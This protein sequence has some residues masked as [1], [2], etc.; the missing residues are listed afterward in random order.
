MPRFSSFDSRNYPTVS[1]REGY[2]VWSLTYEETIKE[3]AEPE[4]KDAAL[5]AHRRE[6]VVGGFAD[7]G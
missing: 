7:F 4:V 1:P 6:D 2:G 3:D 5:P